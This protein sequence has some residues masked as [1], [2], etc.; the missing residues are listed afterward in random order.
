MLDWQRIFRV[1]SPFNSSVKQPNIANE[2]YTPNAA[3]IFTEQPAAQQ[4]VAPKSWFGRFMAIIGGVWIGVTRL[5][6][7]SAQDA[8]PPPPHTSQSQTSTPAAKAPTNFALPRTGQAWQ[9]SV[10]TVSRDASVNIEVYSPGK[11]VHI[12]IEHLSD[13]EIS[14][15]VEQVAKSE[16]G[17]QPSAQEIDEA[18]QAF[19][20]ACREVQTAETHHEKLSDKVWEETEKEAV[21]VLVGGLLIVGAKS[22]FDRSGDFLEKVGKSRQNRP[23]LKLA[24]CLKSEAKKLDKS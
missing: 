16:P 18:K 24:K 23:L 1:K 11:I 14:Q 2:S 9:E 3:S 21:H 8:P 10:Q 19:K 4:P 6:T 22:A 5:S 15:I 20:T 12:N 17:Y 7:A 13:E